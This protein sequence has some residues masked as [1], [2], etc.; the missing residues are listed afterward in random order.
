MPNILGQ[1]RFRE[2]F[3]DPHR[4]VRTAGVSI[5]E[6]TP[7]AVRGLPVTDPPPAPG[8]SRSRCRARLDPRPRPDSGDDTTAIRE[9]FLRLFR[10]VFANQRVL[11]PVPVGR[12]YVCCVLTR[13]QVATGG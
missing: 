9:R 8:G 1:W 3:N 5:L 2:S 13:E 4:A 12:H 10:E 6:I 11:R 7:S